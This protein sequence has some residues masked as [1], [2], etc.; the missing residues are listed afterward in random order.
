MATTTPTVSTPNSFCQQDAQISDGTC[1]ALFP[2]ITS[3]PEGNF[4]IVWQDNRTGSWE[5]FFKELQSKLAASGA[6]GTTTVNINGRIIDIS[7]LAST[8][9]NSFNISDRCSSA[10]SN[11]SGNSS[12]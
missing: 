3:D 11:P 8:T 9:S 12:P 1:S 2:A 10:S 7:C 6:A 5:I 4:G